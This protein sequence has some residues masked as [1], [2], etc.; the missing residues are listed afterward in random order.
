ML[1]KMPKS[2]DGGGRVGDGRDEGRCSQ[3]GERQRIS[4]IL[5]LRAKILLIC[6]HA[7]KIRNV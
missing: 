3:R 7:K 4:S 1:G 6:I 5:S 2:T